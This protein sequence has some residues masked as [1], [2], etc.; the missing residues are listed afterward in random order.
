MKNESTRRCENLTIPWGANPVRAMRTHRATTSSRPAPKS[1]HQQAGY[2]VANLS[3]SLNY[4][5]LQTG[6]RPYTEKRSV[7]RRMSQSRSPAS[8]SV[9]CFKVGHTSRPTPRVNLRFNQSMKTGI[10]PILHLSGI[11]IL[12]YCYIAPAN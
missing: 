10:S 4:F 9:T 11:S 1:A 8:R 2:T 5:V 12:D 7:I 3:L 6:R